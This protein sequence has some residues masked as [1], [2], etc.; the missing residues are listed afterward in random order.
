MGLYTRVVGW[1]TGGGGG[2]ALWVGGSA[3]PVDDG[4]W[5]EIENKANQCYLT[6]RPIPG[7][8]SVWSPCTRS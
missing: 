2:T 8:D 3:E 4:W 7:Y 5:L 1:V 6:W